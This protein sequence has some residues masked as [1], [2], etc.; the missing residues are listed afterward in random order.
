MQAQQD[1]ANLVCGTKL[2]QN[3]EST[4]GVLTM[5]GKGVQVLTSPTDDMG[6]ILQACATLNVSGKCNFSVGLQVA[7]L[8]LK[9]RKNKNGRQ[10][11]VMFVA[12]PVAEDEKK[13]VKI[14][15]G[16]KK[17]G[18]HVDVVSMGESDENDDKLKAFVDTV[19]KDNGSHL[20]TV[21]Q[22]VLPSDVLISSPIV[23]EEGSG[24]GGGG[25]GGGMAGFAEY[26]G[27]D[28]SIDPELALALRVSMEEARADADRRT[29]SEGGAPATEGGDAAAAPAAATDTAGDAEMAST[30]AAAPASSSEEMDEDA[31]MQQALMMSMGGDGGAGDDDEE[32]DDDLRAALALSQAGDDEEEAGDAGKA[33][34]AGGE[35]AGGVDQQFLDPDFVNQ[36]L[37]GLPGV[38]ANNPQI[39]AA[40]AGN[41]K[42]EKDDDK[43]DEEDK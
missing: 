30:P 3:P 36:L 4:V 11:I 20:V 43:K 2:N 7:Q 12:S 24:G 29:A 23:V 37:S 6:K 17:S 9:H 39:Q 32:M 14:A 28:P 40:L 35:E 5:A 33:A 19:S 13:L 25:G 1:A 42:D 31:M 27:I 22:G 8:A 16:L 41:K 15:K 10:R 38:D 26:G 34:A 21:P 18:V